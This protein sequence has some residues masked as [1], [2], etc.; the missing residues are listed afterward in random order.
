[1]PLDDPLPPELEWEL[2]LRGIGQFNNHEYF[3]AHETWEQIW[4]HASG[5]KYDFIQGLIQCA[6]ALEH[7]RRSNPRGVLSLHRNYLRKFQCVP[8]PCMRLNLRPFLDDMEKALHPVIS[9][10]PLPEK[11]TLRFNPATAPRIVLND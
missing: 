2:Y 7:Y 9:A 4:H 6:V 8:D 3:D 11:G 10:N 5:A 1:M